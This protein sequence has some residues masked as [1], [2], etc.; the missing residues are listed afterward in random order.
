MSIYVWT[1]EIKNIYVWTTPVKEVYVWTTKVRPAW[2]QPW[3]N[4]LVYYNI[5][6]NDTNS[7][8]YDLS[9]NWIHQ[10]WHWTPWYATDA[11]YGR[12]AT[13]NGNSYTQ[14]WSIV[15]FGQECTFICLVYQTN[16]SAAFV[17]EGTNPSDFWIWLAT[18]YWISN[19]Y[20]WWF[21]WKTWS[22]WNL[23]VNS[24]TNITTNQWMM[25]AA[26]RANDGT[27]KIYIN[28]VLNNTKTLT[29]TIDYSNW[30]T[31]Q[32]ARWRNW[33]TQYLNWKFKLFIGENRCW[34]DA[35]ITALAEEYGF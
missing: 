22:W 24:Q 16:S 32:I 10:T 14:A 7:T 4:T 30:E 18:A 15:N 5:N 12:V 25:I 27:A 1:S 31:L 2:W 11:T 29:D 34:T 35:E 13:F 26:T 3:A 33:D 20:I 9:W 28:W 6:D 17:I 8:I 19:K 21:S 23:Y